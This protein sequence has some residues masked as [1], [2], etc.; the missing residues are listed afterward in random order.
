MDTMIEAHGNLMDNPQYLRFRILCLE[1]K[2][3][4]FVKLLVRRKLQKKSKFQ[5]IQFSQIITQILSTSRNPSLKPT[6]LRF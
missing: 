5:I 1:F 3:Q 6:K 2:M 4:N